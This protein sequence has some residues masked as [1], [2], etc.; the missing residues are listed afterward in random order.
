ME[1]V[2]AAMSLHSFGQIVIFPWTY[3]KARHPN[4]ENYKKLSQ[5]LK[6]TLPRGGLQ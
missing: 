5:R 3:T 6:E 4:S 1:N 2:V